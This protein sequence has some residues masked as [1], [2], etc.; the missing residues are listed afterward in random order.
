MPRKNNEYWWYAECFVGI[1]GIW[2]TLPTNAGWSENLHWWEFF[3]LA[4]WKGSSTF[5]ALA[6]RNNTKAMKRK[7]THQRK[8]RRTMKVVPT[9]SNKINWKCVWS[10]LALSQSKWIRIHRRKYIENA[11]VTKENLRIVFIYGAF[12]IGRTTQEENCFDLLSFFL[13][14][15]LFSQWQA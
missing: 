6:D 3:S 5:E 4:P 7:N 2:I 9:F 15:F 13:R 10:G 1:N 12:C 11:F 8:T 14:V